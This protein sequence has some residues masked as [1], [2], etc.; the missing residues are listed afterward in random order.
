M[1]RH[2]HEMESVKP[3]YA[4]IPQD[5]LLEKYATASD[6]GLVPDLVNPD[7]DDSQQRDEDEERSEADEQTRT[8]EEAIIQ[9]DTPP[10]QTTIIQTKS[11]KPNNVPVTQASESAPATTDS[12]FI[13]VDP[14]SK[15][16]NK[17][18]PSAPPAPVILWGVSITEDH[19][20]FDCTDG[21]SL[22]VGLH[23]KHM[24]LVYTPQSGAS[25][26][27]HIIET[28]FLIFRDLAGDAASKYM[29]TPGSP[30]H[31]HSASPHTSPT[32][33]TSS[34]SSTS[35][36]P[37]VFTSD[38]PL[39]PR[40]LTHGRE[41]LRQLCPHTIRFT[42][43]NTPAIIYLPPYTSVHTTANIDD[44][45]APFSEEVK[46]WQT[47]TASSSRSDTALTLEELEEN[48]VH[49]VAMIVYEAITRSILISTPS[50]TSTTP[51]LSLL[52]SITQDL[53]VFLKDAISGKRQTDGQLI[54]L[55][56]L[57]EKLRTFAG[58]QEQ[59]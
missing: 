7:S 51:D 30:K 52:P 26:G 47:T 43:D 32:S 3:V 55:S 45:V 42:S 19:K 37:V 17:P 58:E 27:A 10:S 11:A 53:E 9:K 33:S 44:S 14:N 6:D 18:A 56:T 23:R 39:S 41:M 21:L 57:Y 59:A 20:L 50:E 1:G 15:P 13:S 40:R 24:P 22:F 4:E 2:R 12:V 49:A 38:D 31:K 29:I 16:V 5:P 36:P 8:E 35:L 54:S 46:R 34:T 48:C 25:L 28:L